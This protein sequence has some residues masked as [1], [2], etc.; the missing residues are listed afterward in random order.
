M[1]VTIEWYI[2]FGW[3][4]WFSYRNINWVAQERKWLVDRLKELEIKLDQTREA[5]E[6]AKEVSLEVLRLTNERNR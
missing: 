5:A 2:L 3:L 6:E 1:E 4:A